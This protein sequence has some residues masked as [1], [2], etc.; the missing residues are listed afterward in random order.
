DMQFPTRRGIGLAT[1]LITVTLNAGL[2]LRATPAGQTGQA[3]SAFRGQVLSASGAMVVGGPA[4]NPGHPV[5]GATVHLVPVTAMD[6]TS[7]IT[8]STIYAPPYPA[9]AYDEPLEDA[10]RLH[11]KEFPQATT[12]ARGD[13]A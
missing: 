5:V 1:S 6:I 11:G 12:D 10:I 7:R 4:A 9:E 3:T 2:M 13:F 8:A